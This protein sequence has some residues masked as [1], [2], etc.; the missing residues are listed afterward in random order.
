MLDPF[1]ALSLAAAVVQFVDFGTRLMSKGKEIYQSAD[2]SSAEN[3]ELEVIYEDLKSLS[4]KLKATADPISLSRGC[5]EERALGKL[6]ATCKSVADE[7]LTTLRDLRVAEGPHRKWSSF[8]KALKTIWKKEKIEELK[9]R[10][11]G[12][13]D[14]LSIQFLAILRYVVVHIPAS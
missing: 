1:S 2:G 4:E 11:E 7:L 10:L 13:R 9:S 8:R 14:E 6:A 5:L 12:L 3:I